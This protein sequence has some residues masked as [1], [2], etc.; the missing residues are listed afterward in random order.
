MVGSPSRLPF[1]GRKRT[2]DVRLRPISA[3]A[4]QT[5]PIYPPPHAHNHTYIRVQIKACVRT[6]VRSH[7]P[8]CK[9]THTPSN[10]ARPHTYKQSILIGK[11]KGRKENIRRSHVQCS[12]L[13][14]CQPSPPLPKESYKNRGSF[15]KETHIS[16]ESPQK[17]PTKI[18]AL[19]EKRPTSS[20]SLCKKAPQK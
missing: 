13:R 20:G 3:C 6:Q 4:L 8:M 17:S 9:R 18:E 19:L 2:S 15:G 14:S 5:T 16:R 10:S 12:W 7:T 11:D 1:P